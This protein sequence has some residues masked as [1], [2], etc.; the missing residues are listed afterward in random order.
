MLA[1]N[2]LTKQQWK[3]LPPGPPALPL[4]GSMP[5]LGADIRA[6]LLKMAKKYGNVFSIYMGSTRVVVLSGYD[7]IRDAFAKSGHAFSGRPNSFIV[8]HFTKGYGKYI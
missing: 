2:Y 1:Y 4:V 7:V 6:P 3:N 5:F 8:E